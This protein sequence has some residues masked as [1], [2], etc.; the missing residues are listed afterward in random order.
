MAVMSIYF[1]GMLVG[2]KMKEKGMRRIVIDLLDNNV[3]LADDAI[4]RLKR[5][6]REN[7]PEA[8]MRELTNL[9]D[10]MDMIRKNDPIK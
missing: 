4:K 9:R 2:M 6:D 5:Y 1:T 8:T 3:R 7:D 10:T